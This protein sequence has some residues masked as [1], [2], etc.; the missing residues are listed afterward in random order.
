LVAEK[1]ASMAAMKEL[2]LAVWKAE[3]T[4]EQTAGAWAAWRV[5]CLAEPTAG[6]SVGLRVNWK[7]AARA[8]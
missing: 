8:A 6:H 4:V 2:T 3:T 7:A 5:A 1:V